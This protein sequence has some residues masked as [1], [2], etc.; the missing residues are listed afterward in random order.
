MRDSIRVGPG[1]GGGRA[2]RRRRQVGFGLADEVLRHR[3]RMDA[4]Q[5]WA[6]AAYPSQAGEPAGPGHHGE[7]PDLETTGI[8]AGT[9]APAAGGSVKAVSGRHPSFGGEDE[10]GGSGGHAHPDERVAGMP[11]RDRMLAYEI[12][13]GGQAG[14]AVELGA[15]RIHYLRV[16]VGAA[17]GV[18]DDEQARLGVPAFFVKL[19]FEHPEQRTPHARG[20]RSRGKPVGGELGGRPNEVA[21]FGDDGLE[22]VVVVGVAC[23]RH[24]A[25]PS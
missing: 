11:G 6:V 24:W 5:I 3:L 22:A 18:V 8:L 20:V 9:D 10:G 7:L 16:L 21:E 4:H 15:E 2:A 14:A 23:S 17:A 19:S 1:G 13:G 12:A 25:R